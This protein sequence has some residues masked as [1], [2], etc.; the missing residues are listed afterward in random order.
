MRASSSLRRHPGRWLGA[1]ITGVTCLFSGFALDLNAA[2]PL[3]GT[4]SGVIAYTRQQGADGVIWFAAGDGS[5]DVPVTIGAW[6]KVSPDGRYMLFQRDGPSLGQ[7]DL[8][9]KDLVTGQEN[10][11]FD[12]TDSIIGSDWTLD[13]SRFYFDH[14]CS[15]FSRN[16]DNTGPVTVRN[17]NC[18]DDAPVVRPCTGQIAWHNFLSSQGL[19]LADSNGSNA[20]RITNSV[21][22][23]SA[24][25]SD[26]HPA[27]SPD[28][29]W[30]VFINSGDY[31][32]MRPTAPAA[33]ISAHWRACPSVRVP[34][35]RRRP[36]RATA[37]GSSPA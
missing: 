10:F 18:W 2:N 30:L 31:F 25:S 29:E 35:G 24:A 21:G 6:P 34:S 5:A 37:I 33:R 8:W 32:K 7:G 20:F 15:I 23:G 3:P 4:V 1:W 16:R 12:N 9:M 13:G 27:W 14:S 28:G 19:W 26:I 22:T 11:L 17:V 36:G